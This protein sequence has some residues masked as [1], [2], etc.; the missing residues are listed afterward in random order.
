MGLDAGFYSTF[1]AALHAGARL[2]YACAGLEIPDVQLIRDLFSESD[3][4][5]YPEGIDPIS[6]QAFK[7]HSR[8][9]SSNIIYLDF[10]GHEAWNSAWF[11][12]GMIK[13]PPYSVDEDPGFSEKELRY[14]ISIWRSV[15]EDYSPF[16]VDV[17]TEYPGSEA[18]LGNRDGSG[19]GIRV[20]VGGSSYSW[21]GE[22]A[23]GVAYM[24][25]ERGA[26]WGG[27]QWGVG[28]RHTGGG[29]WELL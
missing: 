18:L 17:T 13:T 15:S 2:V 20:A 19:R 12:N 27:G 8:P 28:V 23:G 10:D 29:W 26:G 1:A 24:V 7:L 16:D 6:D 11:P 3:A 5:P 4:V 14:I 21:Y 22:G 9:G 25:S